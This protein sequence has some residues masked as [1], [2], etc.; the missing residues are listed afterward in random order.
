MH[1]V[2]MP[3]AAICYPRFLR[4]WSLATCAI[5]LAL[6]VVGSLVT[7]FRV[8]M[9]V[10][11][12]PTA[13]WHLL[14]IEWTEPNAGFLIEHTHRILGYVAGTLILM[15]TPWLWFGSPDTFKRR[16]SFLAGVFI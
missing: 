16:W 12:W 13:P 1:R 6:I 14:L 7:T 3:T 15:L 10:K 11:L 9:A 5:T 8:G 4:A 2:F